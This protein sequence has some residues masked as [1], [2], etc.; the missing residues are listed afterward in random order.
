M[1]NVIRLHISLNEAVY[2]HEN[3]KSNKTFHCLHNLLLLLFV[4]P[5][6]A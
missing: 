4:L 2:E 6:V 3:N 5:S 1:V